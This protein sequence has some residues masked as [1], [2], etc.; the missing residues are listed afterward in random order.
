ME[1]GEE[2]IKQSNQLKRRSGLLDPISSDRMAVM[3]VVTSN[4]GSAVPKPCYAV[5]TV[6]ALYRVSYPGSKGHIPQIKT[7]ALIGNRGRKRVSHMSK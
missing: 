7:F 6:C 1:A 5:W 4:Q 2:W 3:V